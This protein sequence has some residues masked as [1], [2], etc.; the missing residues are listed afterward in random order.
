MDIVVNPQDVAQRLHQLSIIR[1]A[2]VFWRKR[3]SDRAELTVAR[4]V[5]RSKAK[6]LTTDTTDA[7]ICT[8]KA[9]DLLQALSPEREGIHERFFQPWPKPTLSILIGLGIVD[10]E[11]FF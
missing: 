5:Q 9:G 8:D 6:N 3:E 1:L 11:R 10:L 2:R 4:F 7:L